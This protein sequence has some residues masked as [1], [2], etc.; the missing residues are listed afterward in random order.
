MIRTLTA[1][2]FL[3]AATAA[4]ADGDF[5][6]TLTVSGQPDLY[7]STGSGRIKISAGSDTQIH[8]HAHLHA[9]WSGGRDLD[10]RIRQI[11]A[12]PP[13]KQEGNT[14]RIGESNDRELFNNIS[15]DYEITAPASV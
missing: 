8:V 11:I 7:V 3:A 1:A 10:E 2:L 9:G 4:F 5:D 6:R 15:I 13:I 12:N 14:I